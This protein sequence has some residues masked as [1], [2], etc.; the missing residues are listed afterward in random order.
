M[1]VWNIMGDLIFMICLKYD[2]ITIIIIV[3]IIIFLNALF[4]CLILFI[5]YDCFFFYGNTLA[6]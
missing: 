2:F 5:N 1:E 6:I 3:I 4:L